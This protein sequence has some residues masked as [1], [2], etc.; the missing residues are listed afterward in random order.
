MEEYG[1]MPGDDMEM[2]YDEGQYMDE[3]GDMGAEDPWGWAAQQGL[4]PNDVRKTYE[5]FTRKTQEL[6]KE[7]DSLKPFME[8][9]DEIMQNPE[10]AQYIKSFYDQDLGNDPAL[11]VQTLRKEL[12]DMRFQSQLQKDLG[13]VRKY[14]QEKG[15]PEVEDDELI[16]FMIDNALPN[17]MMAYKAMKF[18]DYG[19]VARESYENEI[20]SA[21]AMVPSAKFRGPDK[22]AGSKKFT[23]A[24]IAAMSEEDFVKNYDSILKSFGR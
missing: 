17:P 13:E 22:K 24:D 23:E 19:N 6:A 16:R 15:L 8:L 18:D 9:R 5:N 4:N 21:G 12:D 1:T 3:Q 14:T 20:K 7:R 11:Q 10:L 2:G